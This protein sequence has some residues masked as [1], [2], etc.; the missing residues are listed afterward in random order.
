VWD[1]LPAWSPDGATIAFASGRH[2]NWD[3]YLMRPDGTDQ[4]RLTRNAAPDDN[5]DWSPDGSRLVFESRRHGNR[6]LYSIRP[7]GSGLQRITRGSTSDWSPAWSP[8]GTQIAFTMANYVAGR[9]DIAVFN[10]ES[11]ITVRFLTPNTFDLEPDWQ[12]LTETSP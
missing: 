7:D 12:P 4:R 1:V 10:L 9:E 5:P 2:H 6:D 8:D 3:V 11:S